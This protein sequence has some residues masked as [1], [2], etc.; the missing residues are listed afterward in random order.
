MREG[1]TH[2][3]VNRSKEGIERTEGKL[4]N[5]DAELAKFFNSRF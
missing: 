2:S 5:S 3:G 1:R 4:K